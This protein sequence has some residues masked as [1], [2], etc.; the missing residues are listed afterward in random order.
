MR[1]AFL[2]ATL[3]ASALALACSKT[4][5]SPARPA[6]SASPVAQSA[7]PILNAAPAPTAP[8]LGMVWI[9]GGEFSMGSEDEKMDEDARPVHR[10]YVDGFWMDETEVTN[11][12]FAAFVKATGLRHRG[13]ADAAGRGLPRRAAREPG[14]RIGGLHA[15][16][17]A[18]CRSTTITSGGAT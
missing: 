14:G 6:A 16:R 10:V 7:P 1:R 17:Q 5:D 13:G 11:E 15:A 8:P 18:R 4:G 12:Q 9:P 3:A 2:L